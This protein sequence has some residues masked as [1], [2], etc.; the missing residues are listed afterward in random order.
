MKKNLKVLEICLALF[1]VCTMLSGCYLNKGVEPNQV[2]LRMNNGISI[3]EVVGSGRYTNWSW[4]SELQ[5]M[6]VSAKNIIWEDPDL[7]TSDKQPVNFSVSVT[8][9]RKKDKDSVIQMWEVY[10]SEA[11]DDQALALLVQN[12]IPRVAK[13]VTTTMT[14]DQM[15]GVGG[16]NSD[17]GRVVLEQKMT[18]LLLSELKE[19]NIDLLDVGVN[20]IGVDD[21]YA[22]KLKEKAVSQVASELAAQKTRQ[23][24]EQVKQEKAQ[25]DVDLEIAKRKN[26]VS[27]EENKIYTLN[28]QAFELER[29][30]LLKDVVGD[31]DKIYFIPEGTDINLVL[32]GTNYTGIPTS[33]DSE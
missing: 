21:E 25:T 7:W 15:L 8:Y 2:G 16:S 28:P 19:C 24:A 26:L 9:A 13:A 32:S 22:S 18:D 27:E 3:D 29:L 20:N 33:S 12:R 1:M 4:F 30:R 11:K 6:D 31:N 17:E 5:V 10:N 14:L 23:L